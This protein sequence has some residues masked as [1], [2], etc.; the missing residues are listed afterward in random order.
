MLS[1]MIRWGRV[2]R[3]VDSKSRALAVWST[4]SGDPNCT[5]HLHRPTTL[6]RSPTRRETGSATSSRQETISNLS[7]TVVGTKDHARSLTTTETDNALTGARDD[8]Q[9]PRRYASNV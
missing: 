3:I 7:L 8:G 5:L 9:H 4:R 2:P 6:R 1:V